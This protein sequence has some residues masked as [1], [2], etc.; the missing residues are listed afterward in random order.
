MRQSFFALAALSLWQSCTAQAVI[1]TL[2][3][4]HPRSFDISKR[5]APPTVTLQ[6][7]LSLVWGSANGMPPFPCGG[8]LD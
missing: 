6:D 7:E 3:P 2:V 8:S 5:N 4:Y 1:E